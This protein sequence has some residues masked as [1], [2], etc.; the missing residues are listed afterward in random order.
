MSRCSGRY[1]FNAALAGMAVW[2]IVFAWA[3]LAE[4]GSQVLRLSWPSQRDKDVVLT[5]IE[6][7]EAQI[8]ITLQIRNRGL[9]TSQPRVFPPGHPLSFYI[10][11]EATGRR[12][13]L[14]GSQGLAVDPNYSP[15]PPGRTI[16]CKLFFTRIPMSSFSLMEGEPSLRGTVPNAVF[17]DFLKIDLAKLEDGF[18]TV[19]RPPPRPDHTWKQPASPAAKPETKPET[20]PAPAARQPAQET[21][22]LKYIANPPTEILKEIAGE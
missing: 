18:K 17:W 6:L 22:P 2:V 1:W 20:K 8:I 12:H 5:E 16:T 15:L 14:A 3:A 7:T 9:R 11:E 21:E 10:L 19:D 13:Y 4:A